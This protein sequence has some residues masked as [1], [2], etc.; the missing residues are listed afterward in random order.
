MSGVFA[1]IFEI[2]FEWASNVG[3]SWCK[4]ATDC[5]CVSEKGTLNHIVRW[6]LGEVRQ[7]YQYTP[8]GGDVTAASSSNIKFCEHYQHVDG[9]V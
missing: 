4:C 8:R 5:S 3:Q 6:S 9:F 7:C 1:L 2:H